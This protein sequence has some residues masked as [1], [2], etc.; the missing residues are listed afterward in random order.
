MD[1]GYHLSGIDFIWD[2]K[3]G[4]SNLRK[5]GIAFETACEVFFDPFVRLIETE[6]VSGE[7]RESVVGMTNEWRVLRVIYVFR[8]ETIR[9]ISARPVTLGERKHYEDQ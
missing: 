1:V 5:H 8:S 2:R 9:L 6:V 7:V 3:K 4:Q